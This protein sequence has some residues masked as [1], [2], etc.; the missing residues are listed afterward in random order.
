MI[1]AFLDKFMD[2]LVPPAPPGQGGGDLAYWRMR[3]FMAILVPG[4]VLAGLLFP[5]TVIT[6]LIPQEKWLTIIINGTA[7]LLGAIAVIP[8]WLAYRW[9]VTLVLAGFYLVAMNVLTTFGPL[10]AGLAWLLTFGVLAAVLL[11][12]AGGLA[13]LAVNLVT[14]A[15]MAWLIAR[16]VFS[17]DI[18]GVDL[19]KVWLVASANFAVLNGV[20]ALAI[21][22]LTKGLD[23][24]ARREQQTAGALQQE[25][26]RLAAQ[27]A[28]F[29][30]LVEESPL[31]IVLIGADGIWQ[32]V[33]PAFTDMTGYRLEQIPDGR[34]W[35]RL[36][37]PD[38]DLRREAVAAWIGDWEAS[39]PGV[40]R[41]RTFHITRPQGD[42]RTIHF[43]PVGLP[44]GEQLVL[45]EDV[46]D[47]QQAEE[48]RRRLAAQLQQAQKMQ[49]IG[50]LAG[51]IAHDF[52]NILSAILGY[53]ELTLPLLKPED[54][55][56]R[57]IEQV[58][59]AAQRA[60]DLVRQILAF[61]RQERTVRHPMQLAPLVKEALKLL[62]ASLPASIDLRQDIDERAGLVLADPMAIHQLLMNLCTNAAQAMAPVP[63]LLEV[64]LKTG[65]QCPESVR[66]SPLFSRGWVE[67]AVRDSGPGIS[68]GVQDRIFEPFFTTKAPGEGTGLG[69]AVAHGVARGHDGEILVESAPGR[70][71]LFRVFFPLA[72]QG[73]ASAPEPET[74][75]VGGRERIL[76]VDDE[77]DLVEIGRRGLTALGYTV[78]ASSAP[79]DA[80][81]LFRNTPQAFDLVITDLSMPQLTGLQLAEAIHALRPD[82]PVI[83]CTGFS[84][85][86]RPELVS[87]L[88]VREILHKPLVR[89]SLAA[90]VRRALD[91]AGGRM[92]HSA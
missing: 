84:E 21:P 50:T 65:V 45:C 6:Y 2:R 39:G 47:R 68:P 22:T 23:A 46:T 83:L 18:T 13:A 59:T 27:K 51:G 33:N 78:T 44:S 15:V 1:P 3:I 10:S 67:L 64:S 42:Q 74:P 26:R 76:L 40:A 91:Q 16:G 35:F 86:V 36:A 11:G 12:L 57:N 24:A 79:G 80:L 71:A 52:N 66:E 41:P 34:A 70:G 58:L 32:Y 29:Q 43:R 4:L 8:G 17:W 28:R 88:G 69:L 5:Y 72:M 49:A 19:L 30:M 63:G 7:W 54:Q 75:L 81:R 61:S 48:D 92:R 90:A 87:P 53:C 31:G 77:P 25:G 89:K 37:Y 56:H 85:A 20:T 9:R 14:L 38:P 60:A 82:L 55:A 73:R 62:R